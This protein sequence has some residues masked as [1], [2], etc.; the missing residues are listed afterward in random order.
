M[1]AS[2]RDL[3]IPFLHQLVNSQTAPQDAAAHNMIQDAVRNQANAT[4]LLVR[5]A[6]ILERELA[7]A[8]QRIMALE[9]KI[10]VQD[11]AALVTDF[12]DPRKAQWGEPGNGQAAPTTSKILYDLFI[13]PGAPKSRDLE[14]KVLFFIGNNSG[15]IW[16]G[17]LALVAVV[18]L[19]REKL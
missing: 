11:Q 15:R 9:G 14:S 17:I 16:L 19:F 1:N 10:P 6:M 5:R 3:L 4:Y 18:V 13:Q 7:A 12:L 8:R 2:E